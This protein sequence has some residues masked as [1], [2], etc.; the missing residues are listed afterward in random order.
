MGL[1]MEKV[2]DSL[3]HVG[4]QGNRILMAT[5]ETIIGWLLV[6]Q[7]E[8]A[9]SRK[10]ANPADALFYDGKVAAVRFYC[11]EVLPNVGL[12]K[13]VIEQSSIELMQLPL[14]AL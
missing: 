2:S 8:V 4:F 13:K 10:K 5:A 1:M 9:L 12:A 6:R 3:Y 7:A 11:R 14:E